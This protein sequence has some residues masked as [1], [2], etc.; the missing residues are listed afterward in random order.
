MVQCQVTA[1]ITTANRVTNVNVNRLLS[2]PLIRRD[3]AAKF[4]LKNVKKN[5]QLAH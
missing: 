5:K 1:L 2:F 3:I 4:G